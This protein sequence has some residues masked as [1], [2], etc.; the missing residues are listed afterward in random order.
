MKS[1]AH[2]DFV[3]EYVTAVR[4]AGLRI[5]LYYSPLDWRFPGFFFPDLY[6]PSAIEMREQY[7]RQLN[8]LASNYGKIDILWFDGGGVDWLG[9]GGVQFKGGQW[10]GRPRGQHYSGSFSW[11]DD[12]AIA[13]LRK[14][15]PSVIINSRTDAPADFQS[16]A[17]ATRAWAI[18]TTSTHGNFAPHWPTGCGATSRTPR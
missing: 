17:R 2:R 15:Q 10:T 16:T 14:L 18:S 13:N 8:E 7:H 3:A 5:G 11:Q 12:Q 6:R 1:A 9:F 4:K